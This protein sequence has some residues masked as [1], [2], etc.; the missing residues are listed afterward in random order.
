MSNPQTIVTSP[1]I[2]AAEFDALVLQGCICPRCKT[3][4]DLNFKALA[5]PIHDF[6]MFA[7]CYAVE[8]VSQPIIWKNGALV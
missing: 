6:T 8:G 4:H 3:Q 5:N 7:M 2:D 1:V